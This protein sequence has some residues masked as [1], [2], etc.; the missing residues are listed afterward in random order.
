MRQAD[1]SLFSRGCWADPEVEQL[2]F[3]DL[4][5]ECLLVHILTSAGHNQEG[6]L[7]TGVALA[8]HSGSITHSRD[9]C[10]AN[11]WLAGYFLGGVASL[12]LQK[13]VC[14]LVLQQQRT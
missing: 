3:S 9:D 11:A 13:D 1:A 10:T 4:Q 6:V 2:H 8:P 5:F 14:G 7:A 12:A